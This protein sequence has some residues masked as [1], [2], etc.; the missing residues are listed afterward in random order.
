MKKLCDSFNQYRDGMLSAEHKER[1]ESHLAI[2]PNCRARLLLLNNLV[3]SIRNQTDPIPATRA[4][5]IADRAFE[6]TGSWDILLLSWLRPLPVWSG[7]VALLILFAFL[8][9]APADGQLTDY[10]SLLT[11]ASQESS[12]MANLS[13]VELETWLEQ[14]G[15]IK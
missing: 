5:T 7:L 9:T 8:W 14:G 2:C 6:K 3:D 1:Y 15:A 10:E 11:E 12:A 13:D 4:A